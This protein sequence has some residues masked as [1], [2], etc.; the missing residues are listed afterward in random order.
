MPAIYALIAA[1]ITVAATHG[2][3]AAPAVPFDEECML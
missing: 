3:R 2:A 1:L